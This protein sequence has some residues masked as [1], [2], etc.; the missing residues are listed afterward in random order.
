MNVLRKFG[1]TQQEHAHFQVAFLPDGNSDC[2]PRF[3]S[4]ILEFVSG[5]VCARWCYLRPHHQGEGF[6]SS[7]TPLQ[8]NK[9]LQL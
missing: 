1:R 4:H 9:I 6:T 8:G 7:E 5:P 2:I 3:T